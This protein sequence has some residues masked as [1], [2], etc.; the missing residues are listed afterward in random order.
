MDEIHGV[1][2]VDAEETVA[3]VG[4]HSYTTKILS[5]SLA[6]VERLRVPKLNRIFQSWEQTLQSSV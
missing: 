1:S 5:S 2:G 3:I 4:T 6:I